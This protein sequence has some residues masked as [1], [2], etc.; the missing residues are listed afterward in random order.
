MANRRSQ[1]GQVRALRPEV[2]FSR[3]DPLPL[4]ATGRALIIWLRSFCFAASEVAAFGEQPLQCAE[5]IP[6]HK[7]SLLA[8]DLRQSHSNQCRNAFAAPGFVA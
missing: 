2:T 3:R 1:R 8:M 4:A 7:R 6:C 5:G